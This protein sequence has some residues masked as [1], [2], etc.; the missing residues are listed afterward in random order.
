MKTNRLPSTLAFLL[1]MATAGSQT[2]WAAA[3][4]HH[5]HGDGAEQKLQ[6]N[7]GK[8]WVTDA[9]LRQAMD[10]AWPHLRQPS[11]VIWRALGVTP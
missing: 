11:G 2:A 9:S 5:H 3:D 4:H 6:L 7:A 8:K 1:A 10:A